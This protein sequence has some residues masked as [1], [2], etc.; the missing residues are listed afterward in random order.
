[1]SQSESAIFGSV[2]RSLQQPQFPPRKPT[3]SQAS[4]GWQPKGTDRQLSA[5]MKGLERLIGIIARA[6]ISIVE[7][8]TTHKS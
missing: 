2:I 5:E 8:R 6:L 3:L 7:A 1:M 4:L